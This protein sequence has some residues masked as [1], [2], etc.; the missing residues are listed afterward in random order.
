MIL[1]LTP[2]LS[3]ILAISLAAAVAAVAAWTIVVPIASAGREQSE[4][5]GLL[6]RQVEIMQGMIDA[7]PQ[8]EAAMKRLQANP[9]I[10]AFVFATPQ[11]SP[12]I[13]QLQS[14]VNQ[15]IAKAGGNVTTSQSLPE[16]TAKAL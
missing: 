12:A 10:Q 16:S 13:A 8:Y 5:L 4:Q 1:R 11:S 3:R 15:L 7:A 9:D 14:Q 6:R 2:R